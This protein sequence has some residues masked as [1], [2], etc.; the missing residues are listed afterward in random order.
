MSELAAG[1][2]SV[3]GA[4]A[5]DLWSSNFFTLRVAVSSLFLWGGGSL[6]LYPNFRQYTKS[7]GAGH[8]IQRWVNYVIGDGKICRN[9]GKIKKKAKI[10]GNYAVI[11]EE[12]KSNNTR[13]QIRK[14]DSGRIGGDTIPVPG[15][16]V[17]ASGTKP[18]HKS[19]LMVVCTLAETAGN[20]KTLWFEAWPRV[21]GRVRPAINRSQKTT[22]KNHQRLDIFWGFSWKATSD[23]F[24][25]AKI[26]NKSKR[27]RESK[28]KSQPFPIE[29][30]TMIIWG[31]HPLEFDGAIDQRRPK[32]H[33]KVLNLRPHG[34]LGCHLAAF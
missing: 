15:V 24:K 6:S 23:Y 26:A 22:R 20:S 19:N 25:I 33:Q 16:G 18:K 17:G 4:G 3:G 29:N 34:N 28:I 10:Y 13:Q 1:E 7:T 8:W 11:F 2:T 27:V 30:P 12:N 21:G 31:L 14:H 9:F 32:I 5:E